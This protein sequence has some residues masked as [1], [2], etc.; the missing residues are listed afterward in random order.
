[1]EP[2]LRIEEISSVTKSIAVLIQEYHAYIAKKRFVVKTK[3]WLT[4]QNTILK[5]QKRKAEES[6]E[7]TRLELL[8]ASKVPRLGN[9]EQ[10]GGAVSTRGTKRSAEDSNP[11]VKV[12][13]MDSQG[14]EA[15]TDGGT[16]PLFQANIAKM[17]T[18]K[19][20]K[21]GKV[22][23]Q[24]F[25]FTLDYLRDPKPDEDLG[26]EAVYALT[27]GMDAMMEDMEIDLK[28]YD[29]ALQIGSKEHF[30]ESS[31]TGETWHIPADD[32]FHRLQMTQSMLGHIARVLNSG[33]F[34]S[35]DRGFS[36]SMT[37]LRR[38][39]KGG[40]RS[41]YKPGERI[42]EEVVKELRCVHE[43]KNKD[44][45][46]CGRA[47]V[48]MREHAKKK[49]SEKNCYENIR[50]D[51]G[52]NSQQLKE[53]KQLYTAAGVPEGSCGYEEIQKFQD[54]L[55]PM[56][57]QLIV[58]DPVR[59][60]VIFTGEQ[61]KFAPKVIQIVKTYYEDSDGET[62]A[63]YDGVYSI[64]A[65]MNR[66]KFCRYCCK[67]YNT[68]DAKH[69]NCLHANCPSCMRRRNK[70]SKGCP[71][72]TGWSKP[73]ITCRKCCRSF[74][75]EDCYRDHLVQK[76]QEE[77]KMEKDFI[78]EVALDNDLTIPPQKPLKSVCEMHRKCNTCLVS[79][80]VKEG[81]THKCGH[82]QCS[83]CLNYVDLYNHR[84]FIMSDIYKANKRYDNKQKVEEK[85]LEAIKEMTTEDGEKVKD[86]AKNPITR[87]EQEEAY[88]KEH[89][90]TQPVDEKSR[91]ESIER[92]KKQL[93]DLGVDVTEIPE[94]QLEEFQGDH[95]MLTEGKKDKH[96]ELV[97]ADIECSIDNNRQFTPNLICFERETSDKKYYCWGRTCLRDFHNK[98][99]TALQEIEKE[100]NLRWNQVEMQ[101]YFHNFRGF[102]GMFIIKQL[103]DMNIK[104]PKVLMTG[105]KILYF[106]CNRLKFKDSMSFLNMPLES[107]TKTFGLTE[108]KKG[109][110]PHSFNRKENQNEPEV[111]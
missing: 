110:F 1:M 88:L 3:W 72:Y 20:W 106:E 102:D 66:S 40:K 14:N 98:L 99:M 56:G 70:T 111:L 67:G 90:P 36:A 4:S 86:V 81:M 93:Q 89:P 27:E 68:E 38:D 33:E 62:K 64:A 43:I 73:T 103:Y 28:N 82:G 79:Y 92:V 50:Q 48:V 25:T 104:V 69:H 12:T 39:V 34:I 54:Y 31:N 101:V 58:V 85:I 84:C 41:G 19:K 108:L 80:K 57:Y 24:K 74:Y 53:A 91:Q 15:K 60:G 75:G 55:G 6:A 109:Y 44:E 65:V 63:H 61:Y 95:Y 7:L 71:D 23:D 100:N 78:K 22:I 97:F 29:L 18:P 8:H 35:S 13:K 45:L 83:N 105:Q 37:L 17:G 52:K 42:W 21:K 10:T 30:K 11:D 87:K 46:C 76:K 77:S 26:V 32:Y 47:I 16:G 49:A 9:E 5:Q 2:K 94:D 51:R 107:F 59:G 96:R